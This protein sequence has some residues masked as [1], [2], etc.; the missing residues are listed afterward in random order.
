MQLILNPDMIACVTAEPALNELDDIEALDRIYR[1]RL[2]RFVAYS[3]GDQ[4]LAETIVQDALLKAYRNRASFRGD[5]AV[6]TWLAHIA[7][8]LIR[9][10]QRTRKFQ[11]WRRVRQ[12]ALDLTE[13]SQL[14]PSG[15]SSPELQMLARERALAVST[16]LEDLSP[17]QRMIFMLRFIEEMDP[18]RDLRDDRN[19]DQHGEDASAPRGEGGA[20]EAGREAVMNAIELNNDNPHLRE[21]HLTDEQFAE[22]L[23]GA[24]PA[25]VQ[26]HLKTC[27]E[28]AAEAERVAGAI[29]SFARESRLWA[30]RRAASQPGLT[31]AQRP[32]YAGASMIARP[33]VWAAAAIAIG[34]GVAISGH[35]SQQPQ[36]AVVVRPT[37]QTQTVAQVSVPGEVMT[38]PETAAP[39][40][41]RMTPS[42]LKADNQLLSAID[43]ELRAEAAPES[44]YGL[45]VSSHA[46]RTSGR[47]AD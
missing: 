18:E 13:M 39:R 45:S 9:D 35:H 26:E 5:C 1:G 41:A 22:L 12:T 42:K 43:G 11:F 34:V 30:E 46:A 4:D 47:M 21:V 36:Q 16:A 24:T 14:L 44:L 2:L 8:N 29:G 32:S 15:A 40:T 33:Q 27:A 37:M 10:H 25:A 31:G 17:K 7:T 38:K 19:A 3:V 6:Y 20:C 23:I 28:C